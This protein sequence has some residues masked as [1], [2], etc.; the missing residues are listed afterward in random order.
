M[1]EQV[2]IPTNPEDTANVSAN[3]QLEQ[4]YDRFDHYVPDSVADAQSTLDVLRSTSEGLVDLESVDPE[5]ASDVKSIADAGLNNWRLKAPERAAW[6]KAANAMHVSE[7]TDTQRTRLR[8]LKPDAAMPDAMALP[9]LRADADKRLSLDEAIATEQGKKV[10]Q[11]REPKAERTARE[12]AEQEKET[13]ERELTKAREEAYSR[14]AAFSKK[15][16]REHAAGADIR[17]ATGLN[18]DDVQRLGYGTYADLEKTALAW[19]ATQDKI[20]QREAAKAESK[21]REEAYQADLQAHRDERAAAAKRVEQLSYAEKLKRGGEIGL[22]RQPG[23]AEEIRTAAID[24]AESEG[25]NVA[26]MRPSEGYV[27]PRNE[28]GEQRASEM[29]ALLRAFNRGEQPSAL[30][31]DPEAAREVATDIASMLKN[32]AQKRAE[33]DSEVDPGAA[34]ELHADGPFE[35]EDEGRWPAWFRRS[36]SGT[37]PDRTNRAKRRTDAETDSETDLETGDPEELLTETGMRAR[38]GRMVDLARIRLAGLRADR[39][40]PLDRLSVMAANRVNATSEYFGDE[41]K[42]KR[43]KIIAGVVGAAAA[44]A[45][46][47]LEVSGHGVGFHHHSSDTQ[48]AATPKG[49]SNGGNNAQDLPPKHHLPTPEAPVPTESAISLKSGDTVWGSVSQYAQQHGHQLT[50]QQTQSITGQVLKANHLTWASAHN[51]PVG[52]QVHFN[53]QQFDDW[54]KLS[55]K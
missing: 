43:R 13:A 20:A 24:R 18:H 26:T 15:P 38:F 34:V 36:V 2:H 21:K 19:Q 10:A 23:L 39:P 14:V 48:E 11:V 45:L 51:V 50:E 3:D 12:R 8:D 32:Y 42:G 28:A 22:R 17:K 31:T 44:G 16:E 53:Q 49:G 30:E 47:Y 5:L 54:L 1:S 41:E 33:A 4:A 37:N 27:V 25:L 55:E 35:L 46:I 6:D 29:A 52:Y 7:L 9:L 40:R